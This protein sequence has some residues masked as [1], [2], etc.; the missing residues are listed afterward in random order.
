MTYTLLHCPCAGCGA[1]IAV[2]PDK[3]PSIRVKGSREPLCE[4][5]INK[6]NEIHRTSQGLD[7][8]PLN[9]EA[10]APLKDN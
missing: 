7:P 9:P 8:V 1:L 5:C 6:W 3:C 2:N 10:Y 4:G